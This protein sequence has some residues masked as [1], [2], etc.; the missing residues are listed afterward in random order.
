[1]GDFKK[2]IAWQKAHAFA[3]AVHSAFTGRRTAAAPGF[4]AQLLRAVSSISDNLAEG[5]GRRSRRAFRQKA[6]IPLNA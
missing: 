1:M 5:C 3:I 6:M 4:R 2:L